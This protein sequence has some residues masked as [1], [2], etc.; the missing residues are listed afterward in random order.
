MGSNYTITTARAEHLDA[1]S[2]I[3]LAAATMFEGYVPASVPQVS[4]PQAKFQS[5]QC[6]GTLWVA[7][8][9]ATPRWLRPRRNAS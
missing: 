7:L 1:L 2:D 5:A 9:R 4:M 8:S 3:E 6:E